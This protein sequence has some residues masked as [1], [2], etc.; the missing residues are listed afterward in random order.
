MIDIAIDIVPVDVSS[1]DQVLTTE[2]S[3]IRVV[4][5]GN[6]AMITRAGETRV[7]AFAAGETRYIYTSKI[8]NADTTATGIEAMI[9]MYSYKPTQLA[10]EADTVPGLN[11]GTPE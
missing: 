7:V 9:D 2:A 3:A 10:S 4:G 5:A 6:V 11:D 8:L 1:D